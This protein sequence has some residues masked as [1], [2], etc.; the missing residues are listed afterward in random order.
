MTNEGQRLII[1]H[2]K[3]MSRK[4]LME[5]KGHILKIITKPYQCIVI[6]DDARW[7][8]KYL[9]YIVLLPAN[10]IYHAWMPSG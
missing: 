8:T 4:H 1:E 5:F 9:E 7:G 6:E 10:K 2:Q 3:L